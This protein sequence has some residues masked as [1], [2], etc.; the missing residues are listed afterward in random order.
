[1]KRRILSVL[2]ILCLIAALLPMS[3]MAASYPDTDGHW[4]EKSIGRWSNAAVVQGTDGEFRPDLS[5]TRAQIAAIFARLLRLP[6]ASPAE[7]HDLTAD[8]WYAD[9]VSRCAAAGILTGYPDGTFRPNDPVTREQ[10]C[11][12]LARA[13]GISELRRADLSDFPDAADTGD[14]AK[15]YVAAMLNRDILTGLSGKLAPKAPVTRAQF[16]TMLDRAI[17]VYADEDGATVKADDVD[18]I[19]LVVAED[20]QI[21]NAPAGTKVV[22]A[23]SAKSLKVNGKSVDADQVHTV[24]ETVER[25]KSA[26]SSH[27]HS[28]TAAVTTPATCGADGVLTYTCSC[29]ATYTEPIPATGEHVFDETG[30]C[31]TCGASAPVELWTSFSGSKVGFYNTISDAFA[32]AQ[33]GTGVRVVVCGD[34]TL[35]TD[36]AIPQ[37]IMLDVVAGGKLTVPAGMTLTIPA[38]A[39]RL[40]ILTGSTVENNGTILIEGRGTLT[41]GESKVMVQDGG[42]LTGELSVPDGYILSKNNSSYFAGIPLYELTY[43]DG[44]TKQFADISGKVDTSVTQVKL[45]DDV[46]KGMSFGTRE[47]TPG[48]VLDLGGHTI[49]GSSSQTSATLSIYQSITIKNGTVAYNGTL[50][51]PPS[52]HNSAILLSG[53]DT[54]LTIAEDAVISGG[55]GYG[56]YGSGGTLIVNGT[57]TSE[58]DAAITGNGNND[59]GDVDECSITVNDGVVIS[60]PNGA[61]IYHPQKGTVTVNGGTISGHTGIAIASGHLSIT[62]GTFSGSGAYV[63]PTGS[64]NEILDGA[65]VSIVEHNYPGG[66]PTAAITGGTF[67]AT[68]KD[69]KALHIYIYRDAVSVWLDCKDYVRVTAGTYSTDPSA[70]VAD[71]Y[72]AAQEDAFWYVRPAGSYI[73]EITS[74]DASV[75][76]HKYTSLS[77][78]YA[79]I[80]AVAETQGAS[81]A[82]GIV[83]LLADVTLDQDLTIG[84]TGAWQKLA[85]NGHTLTFKDDHKLLV[86]G[87]KMVTIEGSGTIR[88]ESASADA[89]IAVVS[90][91]AGLTISGT[92]PSKKITLTGQ[93]GVLTSGGFTVKKA[94][95]NTTSDAV[96]AAADCTA[97]LTVDSGTVL[98]SEAGS[99][100]VAADGSSAKAEV[101]SGSSMTSESSADVIC[102]ASS[103][104]LQVKGGTFSGSSI[105]TEAGGAVSISGGTYPIAS[106]DAL[107]TYIAEGYTQQDQASGTTYTVKLPDVAVVT[108]A[109]GNTKSCTTLSSALSA[110]NNTTGAKITLVRDITE[111]A[112]GAR[113][114]GG[115]AELDLAGHTI[116]I[117][118]TSS[119]YPAAITLLRASKLTFEDS[120]AE[121]TGKMIAADSYCVNVGGTSELTIKSGSFSGSATAVQTQDSGKAYI[122]GG[123]FTVSPADTT[124]DCR[125]LLNR[126]DGSSSTI[127]V[128]GGTFH[129]FDPANNLADGENTNFVKAGYQST[130]QD[131]IYTVAQTQV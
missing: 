32:E 5:I 13:L 64:Q 24:P 17:A 7:Y 112:S 9:A 116:T 19:I 29:G 3:V 67:T 88:S 22:A 84:T 31:T 93:K 122:Q 68:G 98:K 16:V 101:K 92:G 81:K 94:V 80:N 26:G 127:E 99:C 124:N 85:L 11:A 6:E 38:N 111:K 34:Y 108:F 14:W 18:G 79:A 20:V 97:I 30:T 75:K 54:T 42:T 55:K 45:L 28:Y 56:I 76:G 96:T 46:T 119:G 82:Y 52:L 74:G 69:A 117:T 120:S 114:A 43:S 35:R 21:K 118:G 131:G 126:V 47:T 105:L 12:M 2:V 78:A 41:Y 129:D 72:E 27:S 91:G 10:A 95:L 57:V 58:G 77:A 86:T 121:Q 39:N 128:T 33:N 15:G 63:A 87:D 65:A 123:G 25:P 23:A 115:T 70:Y 104:T 1:M 113:M 109:N 83:K 110:V 36:T 51:D 106:K 48:L 90:N 130:E 44:T 4:A 71:G 40:G 61:G 89:Y 62:G 125:Y 59:T 53:S 66:V 107:S 102:W 50:S 73:A 8:A 60:A 49:G 37:G 100:L 103:G